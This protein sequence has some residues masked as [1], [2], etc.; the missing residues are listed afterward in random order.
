MVGDTLI[1]SGQ[2]VLTIQNGE[3]THQVV[4]LDSQDFETTCR[5]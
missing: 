3:I 4:H 1:A 5:S 2:D